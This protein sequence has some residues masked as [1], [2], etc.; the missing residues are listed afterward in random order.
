MLFLSF[1]T[2]VFLECVVTQK[3]LHDGSY[4]FQALDFLPGFK[5]V[6]HPADAKRDRVK[7]R[8]AVADTPGDKFLDIVD[9]HLTTF[10]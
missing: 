3:L 10:A 6:E 8:L 9:P 4:L 1:R 7:E 2:S 5:R